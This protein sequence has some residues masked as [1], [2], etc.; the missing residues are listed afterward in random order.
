MTCIR[1]VCSYALQREITNYMV[2]EVYTVFNLTSINFAPW[3][4]A[5][6]YSSINTAQLKIEPA[7][8]NQLSS[9]Q[10]V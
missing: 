9:P 2:L 5:L 10:N 7:G 4:E 1:Y 8:G 3:I 6:V